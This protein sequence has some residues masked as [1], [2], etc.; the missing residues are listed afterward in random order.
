MWEGLH[1]KSLRWSTCLWTYV[2]LRNVSASVLLIPVASFLFVPELMDDVAGSHGPSWTIFL[3]TT[4]HMVTLAF[5]WSWA[6]YLYTTFHTNLIWSRFSIFLFFFK[7]A[8]LV[9]KVQLCIHTFS[10]SIGW[11]NPSRLCELMKEWILSCVAPFFPLL[12]YRHHHLR[13]ELSL[14]CMPQVSLGD[15]AQS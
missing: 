1:H 6:L 4:Y 14:L 5:L 10:A 2:F 7:M 9:D 15:A 11:P 13:D 3:L 12:C 8:L